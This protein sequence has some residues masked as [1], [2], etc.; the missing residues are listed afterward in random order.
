[1]SLFAFNN[2]SW[3]PAWNEFYLPSSHTEDTDLIY[4][5]LALKMI[6]YEHGLFFLKKNF[7]MFILRETHTECK[8]GEAERERRTHRIWSRL[9]TLSHQHRVQCEAWIHE[10]WA[11][12]GAE[13]GHL[14][15]RATQVPLNMGC[16]IVTVTDRLH[17]K[18]DCVTA[19]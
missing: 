19:L 12:N 14:T 16:S 1:M 15:Y 5:L 4:L 9:Q 18:K 13:V 3:K 2:F 17:A 8:Q 11:H 10:P 6:Y 7:L